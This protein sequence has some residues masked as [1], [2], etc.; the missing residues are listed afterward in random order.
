MKIIRVSIS[1]YRNISGITV[2][3]D[4]DSN[5]I[6]GENNIGKSNFLALLEKVCNGWSF[7]EQDFMDDEKTIEILLTIQLLS[8]EQGFFGDN[9]SSEDSSIINI[10]YS[11]GI[12]EAHPNII[13]IDTNES[14]QIKQ[15]KKLHFLKYDTNSVPSKELKLDNQKGAGALVGNI[16]DRFIK[17]Y[18]GECK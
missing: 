2:D 5:Y 9:F 11:Q 1:N 3:L 13:C 12:T 6:I 15:I 18:Q 8:Y 17:K 4:K 7:E 16:I 14:I 10:K